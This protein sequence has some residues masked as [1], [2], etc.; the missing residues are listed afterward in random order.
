MLSGDLI[1][2]MGF[3]SALEVDVSAFLVSKARGNKH[4]AGAVYQ[5]NGLSGG[6]T[7]ANAYEAC[8]FGA[9]GD[10]VTNTPTSS[11]QFRTLQRRW[12]DSSAGRDG[13]AF[14]G[15][16]GGGGGGRRRRRRAD[17]AEILESVEAAGSRQHDTAM[18]GA[19]GWSPRMVCAAALAGCRGARHTTRSLRGTARHRTC[20]R[21]PTLKWD[22]C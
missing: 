13:T 7:M 4:E 14:P 20:S 19:R 22:T 12:T 9:A 6:Q 2:L 21:V 18:A 15:G 5:H 17:P 8:G 3:Y 1:A 11:D 16:G 10:W